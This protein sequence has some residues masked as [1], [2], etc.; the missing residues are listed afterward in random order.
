MRVFTL[1]LAL[2]ACGP[3]SP[4]TQDT[5]S[6][7]DTA[8]A[9]L[10]PPPADLATPTG[11]CPAFDSE[12]AF[13]IV[14]DGKTRRG[15]IWFPDAPE[16]GMSLLFTFHGLAPSGFDV[17][18]NFS[19]GFDLADLARQRN[20][21]IVV[22]EAETLNLVGQ[23]VLLW[24]ILG[25]GGSDLALFDDLRSCIAQR[26]DLDLRKVAAWGFSGGALWTSRLTLARTDHLAATAALSGGTDLE[27]PILG[28]KLVFEAPSHAIPVMLSSG[29]TQDVWP[30]T[31]FPVIDFEDATDNFE[32]GLVEAGSPVVRCRHD[33]GHDVPND[34]W[35][36]ARKWLFAHT[37]GAP[38][39]WLSADEPLKDGCERVGF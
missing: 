13:E 30:S 20:A 17:V 22:P 3:T 37:Y 25:D 7:D 28:E 2:G 18:G 1:L 35:D 36:Q 27:I 32:A 29:G 26:F 11:A 12:G 9:D 21:V 39:P 4:G 6:A 31:A 19:Q 38:S 15:E 24:D 10:G 33:A 23:N 14:S 8:G 16:P 34:V 5:A